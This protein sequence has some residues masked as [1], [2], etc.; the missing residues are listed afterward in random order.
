MNRNTIHISGQLPYI[1]PSTSVIKVL[2]CNICQTSD[3]RSVAPGLGE[4]DNDFEWI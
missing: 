1:R 4:V 2:P 3:G